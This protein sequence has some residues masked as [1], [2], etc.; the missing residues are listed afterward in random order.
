MKILL[1]FLILFANSW[2]KISEYA[3]YQKAFSLVCNRYETKPTRALEARLFEKYRPFLLWKCDGNS[4]FKTVRRIRY[5]E[6]DSDSLLNM[7]RNDRK[8]L[9][10]NR[11]FF[12][13][14][15][16]LRRRS[17]NLNEKPKKKET[18]EFLKTAVQ[19]LKFIEY[20]DDHYFEFWFAPETSRRLIY[21]LAVY[22]WDEDEWK[23]GGEDYRDSMCKNVTLS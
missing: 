2:Q 20:K 6:S 9:K 22:V 14:C 7:L 13:H 23:I 15:P 3:A 17:W 18:P 16:E 8:N 5:N 1:C 11:E 21:Y 19:Q 12:D 10:L 4:T